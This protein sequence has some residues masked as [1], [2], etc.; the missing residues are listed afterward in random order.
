MS[1]CDHRPEGVSE[2]KASRRGVSPRNTRPAEQAEAELDDTPAEQP[3][4][5]AV[6]DEESL[7]RARRILV[8]DDLA[9]L[10]R[11]IAFLEARFDIEVAEVRR[12]VVRSTELL[13]EVLR[14]EIRDLA[15]RVEAGTPKHSEALERAWAQARQEEGEEC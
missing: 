2:G 11:R 3:E 8:G 14:Q 1:K 6:E 5:A 10:E 7:E 9:A 4:Q 13:L 12:S 15:S